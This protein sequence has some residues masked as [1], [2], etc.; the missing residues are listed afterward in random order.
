MSENV[1]DALPSG[2]HLLGGWPGL[3]EFITWA[4]DEPEGFRNWEV[5]AARLAAGL[6]KT[7]NPALRAEVG[8]FVLFRKQRAAVQA[9]M[10]QARIYRPFLDNPPADLP[11]E[12]W[13]R[14]TKLL[15]DDLS[16]LL[17]EIPEPLRS[18]LLNKLTPMRERV[19]EE[20]LKTEA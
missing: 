2:T 1:S 20:L 5:L 17:L 8:R 7:M 11:E 12:D 14:Q 19:A 10:A 9:I 6:E 4:D 3:K 16:D 13:L 15:M 18:Q